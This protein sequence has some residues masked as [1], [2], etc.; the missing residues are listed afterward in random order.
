MIAV[1]SGTISFSF[2]LSPPPLSLPLLFTMTIHHVVRRSKGK[3]KLVPDK[4][5]LSPNYFL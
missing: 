1:A 5:L 2:L 4:I 3:I